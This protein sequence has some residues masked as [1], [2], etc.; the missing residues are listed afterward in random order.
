MAIEKL[1]FTKVRHQKLPF[2]QLFNKVIQNIKNAEA[3]MVWAYLASMPYDWNVCKKQIQKKFGYGIVK[4]RQ[5]FSY[6]NRSNLIEYSQERK[7]DGTVGNIIIQ[8]LCGDLFDVD[9]P[10]IS[11]GKIKSVSPVVSPVRQKTA[12]PV[13]RAD[14]KQHPTKEIRDTKEIKK[15]K[16]KQ[17]S[18]SDLKFQ[19]Q[20][21][22]KQTAK[23]WEP[24]NPDYDRINGK[25]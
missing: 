20:N 14:G 13:N 9:E 16:I 1:D 19:N 7:E 6:L 12:P 2:T 23:F 3:F 11:T 24:G 25:G 10:W 5:I 15:E 18:P 4:L 8:V 22:I 17:R 21:Q